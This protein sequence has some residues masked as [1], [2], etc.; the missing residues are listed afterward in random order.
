MR[1]RIILVAA[2]CL[3]G[4]L[5]PLTAELPAA[6]QPAAAPPIEVTLHSDTL[7]WQAIPDTSVHAELRK[8][9]GTSATASDLAGSDGRVRLQFWPPA[10]EFINDIAIEPGDTLRLARYGL[11]AITV[12]VPELRA[13]ADPIAD[14][15]SGT[16]PAGTAVDITLHHGIEAAQ[17]LTRTLAVGADGRFTLELA[18]VVDLAPGDFGV[19][20]YQSPDGHRFDTAFAVLTLDITVGANDIRGRGTP[21]STIEVVVVDA[22]GMEKGRGKARVTGGTDWAIPGPWGYWEFGAIRAGDTLRLTRTARPGTV[23]ETASFTVPALSLTLNRG[24]QTVS[25][26]GPA[27]T[28]LSV[29]AWP[30]EGPAIRQPVTTDAAGQ[31][32]AD[33]AGR[34]A[35]DPGWRVAAVLAAAP[36][37]RVRAIV[38]VRRIDIGLHG[39]RVGGMLD[40]GQ[41]VTVTLRSAS[42][43]IE[44]QS[45]GAHGDDLGLLEATL[46]AVGDDG[47][48]AGNR[49]EVE[50]ATGDP[51]EI[52][53][54]I[55]T[56]RTDAQ[57]DTI[58]G[59][60]PSGAAVRVAVG[61][62]PDAPTVTVRADDQGRYRADFAGTMDIEPPMWGRV[63][64]EPAAGVQVATD[65]S[66]VR[67]TL[68]GVDALGDAGM[69][70]LA[71]NS[72]PGRAA[73]ATLRAPDGTAVASG[74]GRAFGGSADALEFFVGPGGT[75]DV[76]DAPIWFLTLH[77]ETGAGVPAEP[78]DTIEATVGDDTLRF[79][80]PPLEG[81][82]FVG[83]DRIGG[84]SQPGAE[85]ALRVHRPLGD[86]HVAAT[87]V[88]GVDGAFDHA[89][90][91]DFDVQYND[92]VVVTALVDGHA[93]TRALTVPGLRLDLDT[94]TLDGSWTP[95]ASIEVEVRGPTGVRTVALVFTHG[96]A[97]FSVPLSGPD[98]KPL[99]L[100]PG[101][102]I[103]VRSGDDPTR[104][105]L[106][107]T[108]PE[109]SIAWDTATDTVRGRATPGG[110]LA[111][112]ADQV[113]Q[114]LGSM[115]AGIARGE[116]AASG[117]YT[118]DF[119]P[120]Y[121]LRAGTRIAAEYRLPS[122][123]LVARAAI[124]PVLS[125]Q[126]GGAAVC[127]YAP[128]GLPVDLQLT[129]LLGT[130]LAT[131]SVIAGDDGWFDA[132]LRDGAGRPVAPAAGQ[133]VSGRVGT[134]LIGVL[135]MPWIVLDIDWASRI[136]EGEG[137]PDTDYAVNLPSSGC[138][139]DTDAWQF[140]FGSRTDVD[141]VF[142]LWL[143]PYE[144]GKGLDVAFYP[145]SGHR[146]F[147]SI[148][149]PY[150][151][152]TLRSPRVTGRAD[153]L[154]PLTVVVEDAAGVER[155]RAGTVADTASRFEVRIRDDGGRAVD[156]Q[157]G[158]LV[159][160]EIA[161]EVPA[162]PPATLVEIPV[163][164]LDFDYD[165][166][167][168]IAVSGP[169]DRPIRLI[170]TVTTGATY[171]FER[172]L[173][174]AGGLT[175]TA[176]EVPPRA[177]WTLADVTHVRVELPV[178]GGHTIVAETAPPTGPANAV[179][180]PALANRAGMG[181]P[182]GLSWRPDTQRS[183]QP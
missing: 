31:F 53:V 81:V 77:D 18:G 9:D 150:A 2:V 137:P 6:A 62:G 146:I 149:E 166:G 162:G 118:A 94:A 68:S 99:D 25:G 91:A 45:L 178:A 141:G 123:H 50:L 4:T 5:S 32:R 120:A 70:L 64:V 66:A 39:N 121:D 67:M 152:I 122:G 108:V 160:L 154:A 176:A 158:D 41:A 183:D 13:D 128:R 93:V 96:D 89:F 73:R 126:H 38:A 119:V 26:S 57:T 164:P 103:T 130:S 138:G 36:G 95:D 54:P 7:L 156:I 127:G 49:V 173:D 157:P 12:P 8:A 79:T 132:T 125:V 85:I 165:E 151:E 181:A 92:A 86:E 59:E 37:V 97:T 115:D 135:E 80:V 23:P 21:G 107:L 88:A 43:A 24:N 124:V 139:R 75:I 61:T 83:E 101:D 161:G 78:G 182:G 71:G 136:G 72:A 84:R 69:F 56:A 47:I 58:A 171:T 143:D 105:P 76:I 20:R 170:L 35:L 142:D 82:V 52:V 63:T 100:Q 15:L 22:A 28:E 175:F 167:R 133:T 172:V 90:G 1:R 74:A 114:S 19:L 174:A 177:S 27:N 106:A 3:L 30:P 168:E 159:R 129:N 29:E 153:A 11:P 113:F 10:G 55:L 17:T 65:W 16:A 112:R 169:A 155:G 14:R 140:A 87:E 44:A 147:R 51:W 116:I 179:Y 144:P 46:W 117:S 98:D 40:P 48:M 180:L 110:S 102:T 104:E 33:F 60:A 131:A 145:A 34:A 111:L 163:E 134:A 42:G 148:F 109:L